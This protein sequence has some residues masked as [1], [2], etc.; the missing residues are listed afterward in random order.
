MGVFVNF[1]ITANIKIITIPLLAL[2]ITFIL[3]SA[4]ENSIG[5]K[6]HENTSYKNT[7]DQFTKKDFFLNDFTEKRTMFLLGS[8]QVQFIN[9]T[10]VNNLINNDDILVYN[11][12]ITSDVPVNR[13]EQLE[14]IISAN[15][16]IVFYGISYRDFQIPYDD[17]GLLPSVKQIN[18]CSLQS[19]FPSNPQLLT[20]NILQE[21]IPKQFLISKETPYLVK[22]T[23][24]AIY[25][26]NI[27][28]PIK[29]EPDERLLSITKSWKNNCV[30]SQNTDA[31]NTMIFELQKNN[32]KIVIFTAPLHKFYLDSLSDYQKE[33]FDKVLESLTKQHGIKIYE[34]EENYSELNMWRDHLH[35]SFHESV[36]KYNKDIASMI[37]KES[38]L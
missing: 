20:T 32:I 3:L 33:Q 25:S 38:E 12:A 29:L 24:F 34:F 30:T 26:Q 19:Y 17:D 1:K 27:S 11:L 21:I 2:I 4:I 6:L 31:L 23:P 5:S 8:S 28:E 36:T 16:E 15:P 13:I 37:I 22:N 14:K 9:V 35:I 7:I 18:L 10:Q